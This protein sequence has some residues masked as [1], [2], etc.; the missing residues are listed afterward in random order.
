MLGSSSPP[1]SSVST[2]ALIDESGVRS[3]CETLLTNSRREVSTCRSSV[4]SCKVTSTAPPRLLLQRSRDCA[5][6]A[7]S[8]SEDDLGVLR[9]PCRAAGGDKLPELVV[10]PYRIRR[11]P[12]NAGTDLEERRRRPVQELHLARRVYDDHPVRHG[13]HHGRQLVSLSRQVAHHARER[14]RHPV[15][16]DHQ[17]A[18]LDARVR[19]RSGGRGRRRRCASIPSVTSRIDLDDLRHRKADD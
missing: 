1:S 14:G 2:I 10:V 11:V 9:F 13:L 12:V 4:R 15:E 18:R 3:S 8:G 16:G 5:D 7:T 19:S 17:I 6:R